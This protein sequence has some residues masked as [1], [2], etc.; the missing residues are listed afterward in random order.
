MF[1]QYNYFTALS[2][3]THHGDIHLAGG[4]TSYEGIVEICLRGSWVSVCD[5]S[6][7]VH[8]STVVC[9]QLTGELNP[10]KKQ[11]LARYSYITF[12]YPFSSV[13]L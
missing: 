2:T 13:L 10:S 9:R 1:F 4:V 3:C 6:W 12:V 11:L 7:N 5:G 8:E